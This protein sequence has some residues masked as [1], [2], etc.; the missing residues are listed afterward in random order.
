MSICTNKDETVAQMVVSA[1]GLSSYFNAIVGSRPELAKKPDPSMLQIAAGAISSPMKTTMMIG[2][3]KL[4]PQPVSPLVLF[5]LLFVVVIVISH[6]K[7][8]M[9]L[10]FLIV[11]RSC[12][13]L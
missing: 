4:M 12:W 10:I 11:W 1:L 2:D 7:S 3:L 5:L 9:L 13:A 6:I 8:L